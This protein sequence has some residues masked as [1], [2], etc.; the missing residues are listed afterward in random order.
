MLANTDQPDDQDDENVGDMTHNIHY[1]SPI[2]R[3]IMRNLLNM[4]STSD[5]KKRIYKAK[6]QQ[7][8][9]Q[10]AS[11]QGSAATTTQRL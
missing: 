10:Y 2:T 4:L 6:Y 11:L 8:K 9:A 3:M 1:K 7:A 5:N